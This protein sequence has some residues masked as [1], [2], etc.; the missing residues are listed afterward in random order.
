MVWIQGKIDSVNTNVATINNYFTVMQEQLLMLYKISEEGSLPKNDLISRG[1][2]KEF[3]IRWLRKPLNEHQTRITGLQC[4]LQRKFTNKGI[5][6]IKYSILSSNKEVNKHL[7]ETNPTSPRLSNSDNS[8]AFKCP[9][10]GS[11][12]RDSTSIVHS[13]HSPIALDLPPIHKLCHSRK[14]I[15]RA[16]LLFEKEP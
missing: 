16:P 5:E 15:N 3:V 10:N 13:N 4:P 1:K 6:S 2:D 11:R 8:K 12:L 14:S 9:A 7:D